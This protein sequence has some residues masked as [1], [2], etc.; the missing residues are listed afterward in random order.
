MKIGI[1]I[2]DTIT[3]NYPVYYKTIK[4]YLKINNLDR[5]II[6]KKTNYA[7]E[8]ITW[9]ND[10]EKFA[11]LNQYI[12]VMLEDAIERKGASKYINKIK[13]LGHEIY[14]ITARHKNYLKDPEG[15]SIRWLNRKKINYDKIFVGYEKKAEISQEIGI[16]VFIDD[17]PNTLLDFK[18]TNIKLMIMT[19]PHNKNF[20]DN[21]IERVKTWKQIYKK[22]KNMT[23]SN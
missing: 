17:M 16:D 7:T 22:I 8:M 15:M 9:Q 2:D 6:N 10:E 21:R 5:K 20:K 1:D 11:F 23:L 19:N 13:E 3:S 14:F 18:D 4:N 12:E